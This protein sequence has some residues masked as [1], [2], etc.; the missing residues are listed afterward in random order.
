MGH[1][2]VAWQRASHDP[3]RISGDVD[4]KMDRAWV[5][6]SAKVDITGCDK[7]CLILKLV[8]FFSFSLPPAL[9]GSSITSPLSVMDASSDEAYCQTWSQA[10]RAVETHSHTRLALIFRPAC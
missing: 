10:V 6:Q 8:Q 1:G 9:P 3:Y 5:S 4:K 7:L 2:L